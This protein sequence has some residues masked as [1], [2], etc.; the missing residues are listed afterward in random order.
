MPALTATHA[1]EGP[2]PPVSVGQALRYETNLSSISCRGPDG[3]IAM[4]HAERAER[5]KRR[6]WISKQFF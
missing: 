3:R 4:M 1:P 5:V 2:P 6:R